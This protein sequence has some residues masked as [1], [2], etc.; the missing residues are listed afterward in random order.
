MITQFFVG[1][2]L[3]TFHRIYFRTLFQQNR[4]NGQSDWE[5]ANRYSE[6]SIKLINRCLSESFEG[7][8]D[9]ILHSKLKFRE[10][11]RE[12]ERA[13][14]GIASSAHIR[15]NWLGDHVDSPKQPGDSSRNCGSTVPRLFRP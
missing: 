2:N 13:S 5:R 10:R 7:C 11:E 15:T 12:G 9:E 6:N 1:L 3:C 4:L 14:E 8:Y